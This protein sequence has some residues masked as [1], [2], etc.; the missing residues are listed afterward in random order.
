M[1]TQLTKDR[2][3][4]KLREPDIGTCDAVCK[5]N[6]PVVAQQPKQ[7]IPIHTTGEYPD[8]PEVV[9]EPPDPVTPGVVCEPPEPARLHDD[10]WE[11]VTV[12]VKDLDPVLGKFSVPTLSTLPTMIMVKH[13]HDPLEPHKKETE[14]TRLDDKGMSRFVVRSEIA[15]DTADTPTTGSGTA[16]A[17]EKREAKDVIRDTLA[18]RAD[19]LQRAQGLD[20]T[21]ALREIGGKHREAVVPTVDNPLGFPPNVLAKLVDSQ[22]AE[23]TRLKATAAVCSRDNPPAAVA[24]HPSTSSDLVSDSSMSRVP[25]EPLA[26]ASLAPSLAPVSSMPT[27]SKED[28]SS[29]TGAQEEN[30][31][32]E[33]SETKEPKVDSASS[34]GP[35]VSIPADICAMSKEELQIE[36]MRLRVANERKELEL[37]ESRLKQQ[38]NAVK[39]QER[40]L[41]HE[42]RRSGNVVSLFS[43]HTRHAAVDIYEVYLTS[44][45]FFKFQAHK[46]FGRYLPI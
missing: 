28:V 15:K 24:P 22:A 25:E 19:E 9:C 8:I 26:P 1:A 2:T 30:S 38:R 36:F 20:A 41:E 23:L 7:H 13:I 43:P 39:M 17:E 12:D 32:K 37:Q 18:Q 46:M 5:N 31:K 34:K 33:E 16:R 10:D 45:L 35:V 40:A 29:P 21:A 44:D 4:V 6:V 11:N 14:V 42:E 3:E 27:A